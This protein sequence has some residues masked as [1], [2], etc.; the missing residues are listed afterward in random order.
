MLLGR[1]SHALQALAHEVG[2]HP[3]RGAARRGGDLV[4]KLRDEKD[5]QVVHI[6]ERAIERGEL[7]PDADPRLIHGVLF[8]AVL[9]FEL[10]HPDGSDEARLEALI[11]LVLAGVLL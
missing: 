3:G 11:D 8:G 1:S 6:Y 7:R 9:H 4:L 10:L 2:A 5:A